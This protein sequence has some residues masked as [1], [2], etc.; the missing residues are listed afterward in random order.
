MLTDELPQEAI[1]EFLRLCAE[2]K[3]LNLGCG[4]DIRDEYVNID[5]QSFPGI[6]LIA[7]V[8]D[9]NLI[10]DESVEYIVAQHILEYIPRPRMVKTLNEWRR[11]LA[12]GGVLEVRV[13]DMGLV[14]KQLYLNEVSKEMGLHT[15]MVV[16]LLYGK[17][18]DD[19]DTRYNGF[20]SEF[21]QGIL[22]GCNFSI[23]GVTHEDYDVIISAKRV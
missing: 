16:A 4:T 1:D 15:E 8:S 7:D 20:T 14:T 21:L 9:L 18:I 13:T 5:I 23:I 19:H 10:S 11:V 12:L 17:Q 22:A 6:N 3:K 2:R